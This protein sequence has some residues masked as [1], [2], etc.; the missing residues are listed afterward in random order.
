VPAPPVKLRKDNFKHGLSSGQ[1]FSI[2][3]GFAG[4]NNAAFLELTDSEG[5]GGQTIAKR[6]LLEMAGG[7][8]RKEITLKE[9]GRY[10]IYFAWEGA[11]PQKPHPPDGRVKDQAGQVNQRS[12]AE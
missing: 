6:V 5:C 4:R 11:S 3:G 7:N 12:T 2:S 9:D 10:L 8:L 1:Y